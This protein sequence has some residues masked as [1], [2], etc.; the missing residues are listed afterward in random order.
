MAVAPDHDKVGA[1]FVSDLHDLLTWA[2]GTN[3]DLPI[4]PC[5]GEQAKYLLPDLGLLLVQGF[6]QPGVGHAGRDHCRRG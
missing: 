1:A 3:H 6:D 2:A 5:A 4:S